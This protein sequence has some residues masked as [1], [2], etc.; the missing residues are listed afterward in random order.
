MLIIK[1]ASISIHNSFETTHSS[2][3]SINSK[4]TIVLYFMYKC[5][6]E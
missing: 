6:N 2:F 4:T 1:E 3:K 5:T